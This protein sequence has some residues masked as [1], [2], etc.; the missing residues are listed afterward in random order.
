MRFG[1]NVPQLTLRALQIAKSSHP[2]PVYLMGAREVM[3]SEVQPLDLKKIQPQKWKPLG[4]LALSD[5]VLQQ[6]L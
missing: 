5:E 3:E 4:R 2:G 6:L 1:A